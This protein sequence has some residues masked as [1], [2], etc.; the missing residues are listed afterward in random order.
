MDY[1]GEGL[2]DLNLLDMFGA[3]IG[4]IN[5]MSQ[6]CVRLILG[7]QKGRREL[8]KAQGEAADL[9]RGVEEAGERARLLERRNDELKAAGDS[10][11]RA[12]QKL[13]EQV[14]FNNARVLSYLKRHDGFIHRYIIE[15]EVEQLAQQQR[16]SRKAAVSLFGSSDGAES[17]AT[18]R[19]DGDAQVDVGAAIDEKFARYKSVLRILARDRRQRRPRTASEGAQTELEAYELDV[20]EKK[21]ESLQRDVRELNAR[22]QASADAES[23]HVLRAQSL[24]QQIKHKQDEIIQI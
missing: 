5:Q 7:A 12:V 9:R 2:G 3:S 19:S 24:E 1:D 23:Q 10:G 4:L 16:Q 20:L 13:Q 17:D 21:V 6:R 14:E 15:N 18:E 8:E 11:A 22:L